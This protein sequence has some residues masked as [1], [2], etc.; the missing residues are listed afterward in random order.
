MSQWD[1]LREQFCPHGWT[2]ERT[3]P[4][5]R[6]WVL[7]PPERGMGEPMKAKSPATMEVLWQSRCSGRHHSE[8][9]IQTL[10]TQVK[11]SRGNDA[12]VRAWMASGDKMAL[13]GLLFGNFPPPSD[14]AA[15][16]QARVESGDA[17]GQMTRA[18]LLVELDGA[19][20][21]AQQASLDKRFRPGTKPVRKVL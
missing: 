21:A 10:V 18:E 11:K 3:E 12:Q 20:V 15:Y 5:S 17:R 2:L 1:A 19:L 9:T 4:G 14:F 8:G 6:T 13:V 16:C 7:S